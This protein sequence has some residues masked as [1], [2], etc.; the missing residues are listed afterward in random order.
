MSDE[1]PGDS[2]CDGGL[3]VLGEPAASIEPCERSLDNPSARRNLEA[4]RGIGSFDDF[5]GPGSEL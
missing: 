1:N 3:K 4:F 2:T 5:K